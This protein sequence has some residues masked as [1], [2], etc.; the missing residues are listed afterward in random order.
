MDAFTVDHV[1]SHPYFPATIQVRI[2]CRDAELHRALKHY[3]R[4]VVARLNRLNQHVRPRFLFSDVIFE[5]E[6]GGYQPVDLKFS[7]DTSAALQLFMDNRLYSDKRVFLRELIQNAVD[8]CSLRK[9]ADDA[10]SPAIAIAFN[11]DISQITI[12]DNGIGMDRQW[13]ENTFW[14]SFSIL[15]RWT[16][17]CTNACANRC[18]R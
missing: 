3:E 7:V 12:S 5:I 1:G 8:A 14:P 13:L 6:P 15:A 18:K 10:Y 2:R 9:L 17:P 11:H 4:V 16:M